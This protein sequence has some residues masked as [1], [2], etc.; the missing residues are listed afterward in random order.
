MSGVWSA[1][2]RRG[3]GR[4]ESSYLARAR[5]LDP[6]ERRR[7]IG[8]KALRVVERRHRS[9]G[10]AGSDPK[11]SVRGTPVRARSRSKTPPQRANQV[12]RS[13][14]SVM[15]RDTRRAPGRKPAGPVG[16]VKLGCSFFEKWVFRLKV[17][18]I[19]RRRHAPHGTRTSKRP[20]PR[21]RA[22]DGA[23]RRGRRNGAARRGSSCFSQPNSDAGGGSTRRSERWARRFECP[24]P[25]P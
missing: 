16:D 12:I 1:R 6:G 14:C 13:E 4:V 24:A 15:K 17:R 8:W 22:L 11:R 21:P 25:H 10:P 19:S 5:K 20:S 9:C 7:F 23:Q 18:R 3:R 2:F